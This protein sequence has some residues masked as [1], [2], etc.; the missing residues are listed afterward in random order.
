MAN[1]LTE[2]HQGSLPSNLEKTPRGDDREHVK[3]ITLRSGRE[4]ATRG[5]PPVVREE[6]TKVVEQFSLEDQRPGEQP[7]EEKPIETSD[8]KKETEKQ[9]A[10]TE[11]YAPIPYPQRLR[12]NKL[13]KQF[14]K[15]MEVFK[16]LHINIPFVDA[17][18]H[19]P[20]YVKFMKDILSRK[21]RLSE[22]ETVNFIEE[23]S[24]IL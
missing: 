8:G 7:Q 1:I 13:D 20:R 16:T 3:A 9:A 4:L 19:M 11:P 24:A 6:G 10:T 15:F 21:R 22:F 14:N 18:E 12:Q 2:L 5:P 17:L 23:C